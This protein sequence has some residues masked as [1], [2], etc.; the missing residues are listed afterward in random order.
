MSFQEHLQTGDWPEGAL[1]TPRVPP[2]SRPRSTS[3]PTAASGTVSGSHRG[4]LRSISP[5][6]STSALLPTQGLAQG[7]A[8]L[9]ES[10]VSGVQ[11]ALN[12]R[13]MQVST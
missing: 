5:V 8:K 4:P 2:P 11:S 7:P 13:A 3:P 12:R 6:R 1:A 9:A 10:T